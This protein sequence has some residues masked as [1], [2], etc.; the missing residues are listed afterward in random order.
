MP[1]RHSVLDIL[2]VQVV[3]PVILKL[4]NYGFPF[5]VHLAE[6]QYPGVVVLEISSNFTQDPALFIILKFIF[7]ET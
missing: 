3:P 5:W 1:A 7:V 2:V 4:V 6:P